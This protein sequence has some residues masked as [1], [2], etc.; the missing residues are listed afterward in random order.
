[1]GN[2]L[3]LQDLRLLQETTNTVG[4]TVRQVQDTTGAVIE[5]T[6][7]TAGRVVSSRVIRQG[8]R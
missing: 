7:D 2:L 3:D 4:Q 5:Y 1:M 6:L 8:G